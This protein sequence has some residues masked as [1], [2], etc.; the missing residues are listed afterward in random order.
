[1]LT[2]PT[3]SDY[4][5]AQELNLTSSVY[6]ARLKIIT[7]IDYELIKKVAGKFLT[8][9][10]MASDYFKKQIERLENLKGENKTV[11][12]STKDG[13]QFTTDEKLSPLEIL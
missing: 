4:Q 9:F 6:R 10:Q 12:H 1:M 11:H 7:A 3:K 2:Y 5:I 13:G 8:E